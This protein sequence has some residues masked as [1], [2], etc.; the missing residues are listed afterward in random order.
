MKRVPLICLVWMVFVT[1]AHGAW[2][3]WTFNPASEGVTNYRA[4]VGTSSGR[5]DTSYDVG[6]TNLWL[7]PRLTIPFGRTNFFAVTAQ[8]IFGENELSEEVFTNWML[9][10]TPP[11][12]SVALRVPPGKFYVER[13]D[14]T[15]AW[16]SASTVTGPT[17]MAFPITGTIGFY[18]YRPYF[19][20]F[21]NPKG[22]AT[23][24]MAAKKPVFK[25]KPAQVVEPQPVR[26]IGPIN[27]M[28]PKQS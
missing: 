6:N 23:K 22:A 10:A 12:T 21:A 15:A 7:I 20:S 2:L 4:W 28:P 27:L 3:G 25:K 11:I 26:I 19:L 13:G 5:Y 9:I 17:N 24:L 1:L 8:D 14:T 16:A 18:R